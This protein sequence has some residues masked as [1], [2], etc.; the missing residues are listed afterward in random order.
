MKISPKFT[1]LLFLTGIFCVAVASTLYNSNTV[2]LS[3]AGMS[4]SSCAVIPEVAQTKDATAVTCPFVV[5]Q[6]D[7]KATSCCSSTQ[8]VEVAKACCE[9]SSC[10]K[11][12]AVE[13]AAVSCCSSKEGV[14]MAAKEECPIMLIV[15]AI[16]R[17]LFKMASAAPLACSDCDECCSPTKG[18]E[19]AEDVKA[20][21][22]CSECSE[23][24]DGEKT[25]AIEVAILPCCDV[26]TAAILAGGND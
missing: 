19:M 25:K 22:C 17:A 8:V 5:A 15:Q 23:C 14:Q 20:K 26:N 4:C 7:S 11:G 1:I 12:A 13:M 21:S 6:A 3:A 16:D 18:V 10:S 2:S 9:G 24:C